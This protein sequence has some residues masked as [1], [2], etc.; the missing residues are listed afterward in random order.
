MPNGFLDVIAFSR[1]IQTLSINSDSTDADHTDEN[2]FLDWVME[3]NLQCRTNAS[4]L[5]NTT[6]TN[7][8]STFNFN[9]DIRPSEDLAVD[10]NSVVSNLSV[11]GC[12]IDDKF[13]FDLAELECLEEDFKIP[14]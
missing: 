5:N 7:P 8:N 1:L 2:N 10:N 11:I 12:N 3:L 4:N 14:E 6:D 9:N 13:D